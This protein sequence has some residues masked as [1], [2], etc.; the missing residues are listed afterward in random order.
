MSG[1]IGRAEASR[2]EDLELGTQ[3]SYI[4]DLLNCYLLLPR[5]ALCNT[6]IGSINVRIMGNHAIVFPVWYLNGAAR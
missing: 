5:L 3:S 2:A 6:R 4:N 1:R